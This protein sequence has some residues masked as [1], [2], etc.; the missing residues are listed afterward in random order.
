M[1]TEILRPNAAGTKTELDIGGSSPAEANW[2]SVDE[3]EADEGVTLV[4]NQPASEETDL[5]ALPGHSGSGVINSV[6]L[7]IRVRNNDKGTLNTGARFRVLTHGTEYGDYTATTGTWATPSQ[8]WATNPNTTNAWTWAEIDAL[9]VGVAL[10]TLGSPF[11]DTEYCT[12][13]YVE[14]DYTAVTPKLSSDTGSGAEASIL[15][16]AQVKSDTGS[17]SDAPAALLAALSK[18]EAG[19]GADNLTSLLGALTGTETGSGA[20][21]LLA[22]AIMLADT[23]L[24]V[25]A[26]LILAALTSAE[27]G[28]GLD[29]LVELTKDAIELFGSDSGSGA[30]AG[31]ALLA[32]LLRSEPGTGLEALR[33]RAVTLSS[34]AGSGIEA[35]ALLSALLANDTGS[36]LEALISLLGILTGTEAGSGAD[37]LFAKGLVIAD[38]GSGTEALIS[39]LAA[40]VKAETGEGEDRYAALMSHAAKGGGI[41][42]PPGGK[43]LPPGGKVS[44]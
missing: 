39:L 2:Q 38:T 22:R 31:A 36:G 40:L 1:A 43:R 12:Q 6:K 27:T 15:T 17:G 14:I 32:R 34:E 8:T 4:E 33:D 26:S 37:A 21:A 28:A 16:A 29:A 42:L 18:A 24:G 7:Y 3:V 44:I 30:D 25:E 10:H 20:E 41:K 5:Y 13:V 35:S 23:G 9:E 19:A 11:Y